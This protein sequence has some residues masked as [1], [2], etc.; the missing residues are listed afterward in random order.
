MELDGSHSTAIV[1]QELVLQ[2]IP[3][4]QI[5]AETI[6]A[7][8]YV[9]SNPRWLSQ[10]LCPLF[11]PSDQEG[12]CRQCQGELVARL[13]AERVPLWVRAKV[14]L[15]HILSG[16]LAVHVEKRGELACR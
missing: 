15:A 1:G 5:V 10:L 16:R 11:L 2:W 7:L 12:I 13:N 6:A 8:A 14:C 9:L 4:G 3:I